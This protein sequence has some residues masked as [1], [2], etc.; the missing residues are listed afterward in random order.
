MH[1]AGSHGR[2]DS[3]LPLAMMTHRPSLSSARQAQRDAMDTGGLFFTDMRH[4]PLSQPPGTLP[5]PALM[6]H[7]DAMLPDGMSHGAMT[8]PP[9][10]MVPQHDGTPDFKGPALLHDF[11]SLFQDEDLPLP[12]A[13]AGFAQGRGPMF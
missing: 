11:E 2:D 9:D 8:P 10:G 5:P 12:S 3:P 7:L 1:P 4:A 6:T 13:T